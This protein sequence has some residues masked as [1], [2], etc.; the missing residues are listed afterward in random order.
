MEVKGLTTGATRIWQ[1]WKDKVT[2]HHL[3][4]KGQVWHVWVEDLCATQAC[5]DFDVWNTGDKE[6]WGYVVHM[7]PKGAPEDHP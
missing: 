6:H 3:P 2:L 5:S 1:T 7:E 4:E